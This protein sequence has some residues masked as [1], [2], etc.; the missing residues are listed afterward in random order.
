MH[1]VGKREPSE[2]TELGA[3]ALASGGTVEGEARRTASDRDGAKV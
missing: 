1:V 3:G 2:A